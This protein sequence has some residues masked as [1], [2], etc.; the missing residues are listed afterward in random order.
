M[1]NFNE[2]IL[3]D[4]LDQEIGQMEKLLAHQQGLRHRAFSVFLFNDN[5]EILLQQ[6]A[7]SKY[8]SGGLWTN[9]CCSH[10]SPN[11]TVKDAAKRR[12]M[13]E[14][15][16]E[17][18][19]KQL[20]HFEYRVGFENG[21]I[22]HEVDHVLMGKFHKTPDINDDEAQDYKWMTLEQIQIA[23]DKEPFN[24]TFWFKHI[25]EH[26]SDQLEQHINENL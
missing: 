7:D 11:E 1:N 25:I 14:L 6:R 9:A 13:E 17:C 4:S 18:D 2:V 15:F 10:P 19:V 22:E 24:F 20:F 3:V 23:I 16:V 26:Y 21:L 12:L 8:H 5:K